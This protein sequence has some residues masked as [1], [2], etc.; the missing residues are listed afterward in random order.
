M[1]IAVLADIHLADGCPLPER[2]ADIADILLRRTVHRLNRLIRPDLTLVLGDLINDGERVDAVEKLERLRE[3]LSL[4]EGP[5]IVLPGNHDL[6]L[7]RFHQVFPPPP[8]WLDVGGVRFLPCIDAEAPGYNATR[9][10]NDLERMRQARA[11]HAGPIVVLHHVPLFPPGAGDCPYNYTNADAVIAAMRE[12]GIGLALGGHYHRGFELER[13]GITYLCCPAL[14]EAPFTFLE[15]SLENGKMETV[16]HELRLP[17]ALGLVD[18]HTHT[19]FAYCSEN[20]DMEKAAR[21]APEFG[22]KG[23]ALT[24]HTSQLY[25]SREDC[26]RGTYAQGMAGAKTEDNRMPD[27]WRQ[28]AR[29]AAAHPRLRVGLEVDADGAGGLVLSPRDRDQAALLIGAIHALPLTDIQTRDAAEIAG[30]FLSLQKKLVRTGIGILAHPLRIFRRRGVATPPAVLAPTVKMLREN[31]V[32]AEINFHTNEPDPEF[33]K[34]CLAAGV[35]LA[36]GSDAH[37]LYEIGE[38]APHLQFL[39]ELGCG[40]ADLEDVLAWPVEFD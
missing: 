14:C 33:F 4:L 38:F 12:S 31:G 11:N 35:K 6:P 5:A 20:M 25:F 7:D 1:R 30:C 3:T 32:A 36:L 40:A 2:N 27:Y 13:D 39:E 23:L 16:R 28:A 15:V 37:N 29:A 19:Q 34:Q 22:L 26:N 9:R 10:E 24:E 8:D 17:E 18:C 21:L